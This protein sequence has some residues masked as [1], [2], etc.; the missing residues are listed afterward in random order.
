MTLQ[1]PSRRKLLSSLAHGVA[2][3]LLAPALRAGAAPAPAASL[4]ALEQQHGGRLGA[5]VLDARS[6]ELL[7]SHRADERFGLCSTFK[8]LLAAAVLR[9]ADAG[10][11]DLSEP[12]SFGR[13]DLVS[14]SPVVEQHL[15]AGDLPIR[16]LA[17]AIQTTS[18]N[19][20]ANLLL[21]RFG[22]PQGFTQ[23]LR[24]LG[25]DTTRLDRLEPTMNLVL[26]G[27]VHDTT[28]PR[29]MAT[30]VARLFAGDLLSVASRATLRQWMLETRTG[31]KRL[32]A[33]FPA[34]WEAGDKTG[35]GIAKGMPNR[36]ND[37]AVV[38]RDG[39]PALVVAAYYEA[40][41][42]YP[43]MRAEDDAVLAQVGRVA[44]QA[45]G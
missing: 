36:H 29:A 19:A 14:H 20:A 40:D 27:E 38:W 35:T 18:D 12:L 21:A 1:Q 32:R 2:L 10:R 24:A 30:T 16:A 41:G 33:G 17:H 25:D 43:R 15:A 7:D 13:D 9:E 42:H 37:V 28:T 44:A 34:E 31:L 4:A 8:L 26:P 45:A 5:C 11:L 22:G 23:Y 3:A 6:M 39:K